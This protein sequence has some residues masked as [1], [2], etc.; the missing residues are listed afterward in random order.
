MAGLALSVIWML[1]IIAVFV[2]VVYLALWVLGQLGITIP[3]RV[4]QVIWV[5]VLL[6]VL[7]WIVS[8]LFVGGSAI[9]SLNP[10]G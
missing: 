1:I 7:Y 4:A 8:T 10:P 2:G 3:P 5:I 9:P 6:V